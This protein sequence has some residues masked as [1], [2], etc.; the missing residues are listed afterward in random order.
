[1]PDDLA[2][3]LARVERLAQGYRKVQDRLDARAVGEAARR[4]LTR[5]VIT[6]LALRE[7]C[8]FARPM[9][10]PGRE[11]DPDNWP[12]R[13]RASTAAQIPAQRVVFD[14]R[15]DAELL[16]D[17]RITALLRAGIGRDQ[18]AANV[19]IPPATAER[20]LRRWKTSQ[21]GRPR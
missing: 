21:R 13:R 17:P 10:E 14:R 9:G 5:K 7:F 11:F 8:P 12:L 3:D 15:P 6:V 4:D 18:L 20:L 1:M 19:R 16:G 2:A